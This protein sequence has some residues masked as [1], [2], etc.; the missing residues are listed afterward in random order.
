MTRFGSSVPH[1]QR[2]LVRQTDDAF[3]SDRQTE[4]VFGTPVGSLHIPRAVIVVVHVA[5]ADT[6]QPPPAAVEHLLVENR[7]QTRVQHLSRTNQTGGASQ[8]GPI[9][10]RKRGYILMTDQSDTGNA[11]IFAARTN[12]AQ[13]ARTQETRVYSHDGPIGHRKHGYILT[14]DSHATHLAH[15]LHE[16]GRANAHAVLHGAEEARVGE[17]H[18]AQPALVAHVLHPRVRLPLR[19]EEGTEGVRR[20]FIDQV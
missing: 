6:D 20:G 16:H 9:G 12:R 7:L 11:G 8:H 4:L 13:E 17:L 10:H 14:T 2:I 5:V 19:V 3:L 18:D 15:V 1:I